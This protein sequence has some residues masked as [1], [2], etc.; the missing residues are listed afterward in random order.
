MWDLHRN[1]VLAQPGGTLFRMWNAST[2][3][4][5]ANTP[6][7][8]LPVSA[9]YFNPPAGNFSSAQN[10]AIATSTSGASIRF[11]TDGSTPS[12]T[13]GTLYGGP[14]PLAATTTVKAIAYKSGIPD[15]S[16]STAQF[17][18]YPPGTVV[19]TAGGSFQN[20]AFT[21]QSGGFSATFTATP[22]ASPTDGVIGLSAAAAS[23]YADLAVI[24]RFNASGMIDA[25]NGGVYQ[26]A[27]SIPYSPNT[28]YAFR[29]V[30]NMS[31]HTYSAYV[32][33]AGG[34]EQT[35][36]LNHAFRTEQGGVASLTTW[37]AN[38]D[39]SATGTS[40]VVSNFSAGTDVQPPS[41][42]TGLKV[43]P[44]KSNN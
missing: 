29:L 20:T 12:P 21:S 41:R 40:L 39:A 35:I 24:I 17:T 22:S 10:V 25:R 13:A 37:N 32:T 30:V 19:A 43:D 18:F 6:P 33:P 23:A 9:P 38:V 7:G 5:V 27:A 4:W 15:S 36:C 11:T 28:S 44:R 2:N 14:V 31:A 1:S 26:A 34:A 16:V 3:Q 8:G 42:P